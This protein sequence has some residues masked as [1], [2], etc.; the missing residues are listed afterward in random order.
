MR[1]ILAAVYLLGVFGLAAAQDATFGPWHYVDNVDLITDE[2][3]SSIL[4]G[5][6]TYPEYARYSGMAIRCADWS[7]W[8]VEVFFI[9]DRYLGIGDYYSVIYRLDQGEPVSSSWSASTSHEGAFAP[10]SEIPGLLS[11]MN[12]ASE[13]VFRITSFRQDYTYVVPVQRLND[14]IYRLGCYTGSL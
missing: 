12:R 1:R 6:T 3:R 2:N 8:G 4:S 9:A 7:P 10:L 14:A 13:L 5:A 11:N